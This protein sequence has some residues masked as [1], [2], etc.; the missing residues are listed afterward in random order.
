MCE[1]HAFLINSVQVVVKY[2]EPAYMCSRILLD[3]IHGC[4]ILTAHVMKLFAVV[5]QCRFAIY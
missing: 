4:R 1:S 5:L 2:L 3:G